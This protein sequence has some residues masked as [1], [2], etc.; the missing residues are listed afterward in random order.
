MVNYLPPIWHRHSFVLLL[1]WEALK[2]SVTPVF[3]NSPN[4]KVLKKDHIGHIV[5]EMMSCLWGSSHKLRNLFY[6][7]ICPERVNCEWFF[8]CLQWKFDLLLLSISL[9]N[10]CI[11]LTLLRIQIKQAPRF[12]VIDISFSKNLF[13]RLQDLPLFGNNKKYIL[14]FPI[15][16]LKIKDPW[17]S[18]VTKFPSH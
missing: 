18:T 12:Y 13:S 7:S 3:I 11:M 6:D 1:L 4:A 16:C 10:R 2:H 8:D 5:I 9:R 15:G 14:D 17:V